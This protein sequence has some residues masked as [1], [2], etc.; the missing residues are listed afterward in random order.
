MMN[1]HSLTTPRARGLWRP[2][3]LAP[4]LLLLAAASDLFGQALAAPDELRLRAGDAVRIQ[5]KDEPAFSGEFPVNEDGTILL[6]MV[7]LLQAAGRPFAELT[8]EL[9][10][11]YA[12]E[13]IEPVVVIT[14][15]VRI[16]VLG[17]VRVPGVFPV[18]PTHTLADVLACL[19]WWMD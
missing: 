16:A 15:L 19:N 13:L 1:A 5:V 3:A 2:L 18:D 12:R 8:A 10:S 11:V 6:P 14:P 17:E 4:A 9:R 7:G